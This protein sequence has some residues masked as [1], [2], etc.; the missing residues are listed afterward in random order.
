MKTK[1]PLTKAIR[2]LNRII[3]SENL[4]R[5]ADGARVINAHRFTDNAGVPGIALELLQ[6]GD[7]CIYSDGA[8]KNSRGTV[9]NAVLDASR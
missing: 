1:N 5:I 8:F 3:H 7:R 2:E 4:Y 6:S 9:I